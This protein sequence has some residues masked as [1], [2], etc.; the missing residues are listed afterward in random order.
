[1]H[2]LQLACGLHLALNGMEW[3]CGCPIFA[4]S[5]RRHRV[6]RH[7]SEARNTTLPV[8]ELIYSKPLIW[9]KLGANLLLTRLLSHTSPNRN[10]INLSPQ[11]WP[12]QEIPGLGRAVQQCL[13]WFCSPV[14]RM[15]DP[16]ASLMDAGSPRRAGF[17]VF[18]ARACRPLSGQLFC[19]AVR[20]LLVLSASVCSP[21]SR[22]W[23][24]AYAGAGS[25]GPGA[26]R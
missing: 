17:L 13:H 16:D 6:Y 1:M 24:G 19:G 5:P 9:L 8:N 7:S 15:C 23:P 20:V 10:V 11:P 22:D 12:G 25:C 4:P 14:Q 3:R 21:R 18:R 26:Q 2:I